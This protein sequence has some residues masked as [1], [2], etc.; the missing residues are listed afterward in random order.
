[1]TQRIQNIVYPIAFTGFL[2]LVLT[3][4]V[5]D[6]D[7]MNGITIAKYFWF[8]SA[9]S[10]AGLITFL[11]AF[12]FKSI[13]SIDLT[14]SIMIGIMTVVIIDISR[15]SN[16][17]MMNAKIFLLLVISF[18]FFDIFFNHYKNAAKAFHFVIIA[19]ALLEVIWG[20]FQLYAY[21][22]DSQ[23]EFKL[24]GSIYSPYAYAILLAVTLPIALYW[25]ITLYKKLTTRITQYNLEESAEHTKV[26]TIDEILLFLLS[27]FGLIGILSILPFTAEPIAWFVAGCSGLFVLYFK[28]N[29]HTIVKNVFLNNRKR[30]IIFIS[31]LLLAVG[32]LFSGFYLLQKDKVDE[33]LLTWKIS[34][35]V[36]SGHPL[37][38]VGI[39]NFHKVFGDFQSMYFEQGEHGERETLLATNPN[40][41]VNDFI[42]IT[43]ENG[44]IG[45]LLFVS[46]IGTVLVRSF[47]DQKRHPEKLAITGALIAFTITGFLSSPVK[48]LS[49]AIVLILLITLGTS[50]ILPDR[51]RLPKFVPALATVVLV[52]ITTAIVYPQLSQYQTYKEWAHGRLYYNMKI[53][54][55]AA[56]IYAPLTNTLRHPR[57][58]EEYGHALAQSGQHEKSIEILQQVVQTIP[59]PMIYNRIG[60]SYQALGL[61]Q[62]A[63][64]N[65]QK[66][67]HMLPGMVYPNFLLANL[68]HEMGLRDK[69]LECA[70]QVISQKPKKDSKEAQ[71]MKAQMEQLI[72][73]LD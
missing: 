4:L 31:S 68:Y 32:G 9:L 48:S 52:G 36:V 12:Y 69:S 72:Q 67:H 37:L 30:A 66:A 20:Y 65:F 58:L 16:M 1:M 18:F 2:L 38:G 45:F 44:I 62:L 33:H 41:P 70:R 43:A 49:L 11:L 46:L 5:T 35:Q 25:T 8:Y 34:L 27:A 57:L 23:K 56:K 14:K 59:D 17:E 51:R 42:R 40:R 22:P 47:Q 53:Y 60:K 10:V 21:I 64:Q 63:E 26:E 73:S 6:P 7:S 3:I 15:N 54:A 28:L 24:T 55:T 50:D 71:D 61:Y 39:G 19:L 13:A 29:I